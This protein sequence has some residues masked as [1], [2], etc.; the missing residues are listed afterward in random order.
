MSLALYIFIAVVVHVSSGYLRRIVRLER[1]D[2]IGDEARRPFLP[3]CCRRRPAD[4]TAGSTGAKRRCGDPCN[5]F[6]DERVLLL[7]QEYSATNEKK[8]HIKQ[9]LPAITSSPLFFYIQYISY[10]NLPI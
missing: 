10:Y 5:G 8:T 7:L 3:R 4:V 9:E 2:R 6:S 1:L